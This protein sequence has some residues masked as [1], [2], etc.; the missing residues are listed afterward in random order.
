MWGLASFLQVRI[1]TALISMMAVLKPHEQVPLTSQLGMQLC[2]ASCNSVSSGPWSASN[3]S[4]ECPPNVN[5]SSLSLQAE[6]SPWFLKNPHHHIWFIS[7]YLMPWEH[8][9]IKLFFFLLSLCRSWNS[10]RLICK[11]VLWSA[12]ENLTSKQFPMRLWSIPNANSRSGSF[13]SNNMFYIEY[14]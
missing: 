6:H 10:Q 3:S 1:C 13:S 2:Q 14:N 5:F 8:K 7:V 11:A 9:T 4:F 12:L